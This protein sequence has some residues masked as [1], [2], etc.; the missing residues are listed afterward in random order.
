MKIYWELNSIPELQG[1]PKPEQQLLWKIGWRAALRIPRIRIA[2]ALQIIIFMIGAVTP[3]LLDSFPG[4]L[5][6]AILWGGLWGGV[7]AFGA[8]HFI[9]ATLRPIL[10]M[11]RAALEPKP[12]AADGSYYVPPAFR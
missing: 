11:H 1:L 7:G 9:I 6:A 8:N 3:A 12:C 2:Y 4:G 10:A 5:P